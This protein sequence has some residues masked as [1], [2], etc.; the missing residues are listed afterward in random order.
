MA[1]PSLPENRFIA[2]LLQFLF[3]FCVTE[4]S[5]FEKFV[6]KWLK[7]EIS[8]T[9]DVLNPRRLIFKSAKS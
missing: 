4:R 5:I 7:F 6:F 1:V 8:Q 9:L 2:R 3:E